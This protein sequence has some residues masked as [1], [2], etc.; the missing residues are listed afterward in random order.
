MEIRATL[1]VFDGD[2]QA[3]T[4]GEEQHCEDRGPRLINEPIT[5]RVSV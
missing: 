4:A 5:A 2:Y 3:G 1:A